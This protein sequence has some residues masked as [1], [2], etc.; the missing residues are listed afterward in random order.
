MT[1]LMLVVDDAILAEA[2]KVVHIHA[3]VDNMKLFVISS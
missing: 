3:I 1:A 2:V